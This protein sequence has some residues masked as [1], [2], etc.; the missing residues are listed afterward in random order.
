MLL[1]E[2]EKNNL[3]QLKRIQKDWPFDRIVLVLLA[4]LSLVFVIWQR[5][6]IFAGFAVFFGVYLYRNWNGNPVV[7]LLIKIIEQEK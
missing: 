5:E 7:N 4:I 6:P 1:N 2:R 3:K